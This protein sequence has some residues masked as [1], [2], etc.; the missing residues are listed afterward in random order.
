MSDHEKAVMAEHARYWTPLIQSGRVVVFGSVLE[1]AGVW[2]LAV[3]E[4]QSI[5]EVRE[6][7]ERDPAVKTQTCTF[8]IG[9]MLPGAVVR[10]VAGS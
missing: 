7:A 5:D 10:P 1:P 4:A 6:I 2:G 8:E 3:L 9:V